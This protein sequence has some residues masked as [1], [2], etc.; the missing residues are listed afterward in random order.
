MTRLSVIEARRDLA[1]TLNLAAYK[2]ERIVL[3]RRGKDIA[4]IVSIDDLALLEVLEDRLDVEETDRIL[5]EMKDEDWI[6][7]EQVRKEAGLE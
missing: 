6:P 2:G 4:A 3:H 5:A 7:Y 1:E